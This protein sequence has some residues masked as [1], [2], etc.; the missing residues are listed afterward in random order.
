MSN[1][2]VVDSIFVSIASFR[3]AELTNTLYSLLSQA[4]DLG[5]IHVCIFSQDEDD[6]HPKLENLFDLFG[7]S[8]YTYKKINY[9]DSSGVG[10]ARNYIQDFIKPE[11]DFFL[12][13]DSHSRF[14]EHWDEMLVDD[15]KKCYSNWTSEIILTSYPQGYV[16]DEYGNTYSDKF[17]R[18]TA[19]K[20]VISESETLRYNCKYTEYIGEDFGMLTG[21][22]CAGMVFGKTESFLNTRYDPCIYFNGEE[23]TLSIRFYEKGVKLIAPPRNYIFHDYSGK[24]R[25]RQ[26]DGDQ[27]AHI[28]NDQAS[29][30]RLNDFYTGNLADERYSLIDISSLQ[31]WIDCFVDQDHLDS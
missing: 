9:V 6:K 11:H 31:S 29:A 25:K 26:W 24:K 14:A 21:Y 7:V 10:Y 4:K 27:E 8:D 15:Y 13:I 19:V 12:Q 16:Y 1:R 23:Q 20:G 28:K 3:D 30:Q 22:F 2:K 18:P 17:E 5:K